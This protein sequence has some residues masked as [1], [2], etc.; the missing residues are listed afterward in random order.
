MYKLMSKVINERTHNMLGRQMQAFLFRKYKGPLEAAE[1]NMPHIGADDVLV[2]VAATSINQLDEM[3][4]QGTFKLTLPYS[5]PLILGSDLAGEVVQVGTNVT[6]F[7]VGDL[8]YGKVDLTRLG[9]F[10]EYVAVHYSDVALKPAALSMP[11]A[12]SMPLVGLTAWQALVER[13][14]L[15]QGQTVLIHGGAGGVGSIA[16]QLAKTLGATVATTVSS[17]NAEFVRELGADIV[18]DYQ[19]EDFSKSLRNIDLVL[20]TQ[21]GVTLEKSLGVLRRGGKAIGIAGPPDANYA[22]QARLNPILRAVI[23]S[24]SSKI[25]RKAKSLGVTYEFLFVHSSGAQLAALAA[26]IETKAIRPVVGREFDFEQTP[27]ALAAVAQGKIGRGKAVITLSK[28]VG[29]N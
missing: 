13:G 8:V 17:K 29:S 4:R 28:D 23:T 26:L 18:I 10:A 21:G 7:K 27:A 6:S 25:T 1:V 5:L 22:R 9:T 12:A 2:K 14:N 19:T 15:Q 16:I 24:L 20:D 3:L 11:E